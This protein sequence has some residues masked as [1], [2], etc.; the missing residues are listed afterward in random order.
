VSG[1][2]EARTQ[3]ILM[4][5][6]APA[7]LES[8]RAIGYSFESAIADILDNSISAGA[9]N[10]RIEFSPMGDAYVAILD[11]GCGMDEQ[12]LN[13]AMRHGSQHPS[14]ERAVSDMG[15]FGL[16]L[17]T[18]SLSQ[19]R[20]LTV[21]SKKN[22]GVHARQW[23]LDVISDR[24]DWVLRCPRAEDFQTIPLV[25]ALLEIPSGTVVLWR[26]LDRLS[27]GESSAEVA[28]GNKVD[29]C[30]EH[31]ALVF[32]RLMGTD[33]KGL[34]ILLNGAKVEPV[35]PFLATH[36]H[37]QVL[38]TETVI[39]EGASIV[40][41]PHILPHLSKLK[42]KHAR[43][44]GAGEFGLRKGQGLYIYRNRRLIIWGT[45]FRMAPQDELTKLARVRVDIP[46]SLD[47][48]WTL[49]VKKSAAYPPGVVRAVMKR[50]LGRIADTSR[51]VYTF[52]GRRTNIEHEY[53]WKR[54]ATRDGYSYSINREHPLIDA[55]RRRLGPEEVTHL[56]DVLTLIEQSFPNQALYADMAGDVKVEPPTTGLA[57]VSELVEMA[58][59]IVGALGGPKT[60]E[61]KTFLSKLEQIEPFSNHKT[62]LEAVREE[63]Y[64]EP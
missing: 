62:G 64:R 6:F 27:A 31:L 20:Q 4:A 28:L 58:R 39:C 63:I 60:E 14:Q 29:Q 42:P 35:D 43:Q 24:K 1:S 55:L 36:Q 5:P 57:T 46:N 12:G 38:P 9:C 17:K 2:A 23:D 19:C 44:A 32:H 15:R 37:T 26:K 18:A 11:D 48:L 53:A 10:I 50:I 52:R 21:L 56:A 8:M 3:E 34:K 13:E 30:R 49:D 45:W 16:G 47:H 59:R 40:I 54:L 33:D 25:N 51:R 41:V 22:G 7:L 61:G